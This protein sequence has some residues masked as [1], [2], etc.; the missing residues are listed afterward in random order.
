MARLEQQGMLGADSPAV[1][2]ARE[3]CLRI[4]D[5]LE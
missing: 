5:H 1:W 4:E 2:S 3:P